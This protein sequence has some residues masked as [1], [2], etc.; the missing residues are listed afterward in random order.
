MIIFAPMNW[1]KCIYL[2][3]LFCAVLLVQ[4]KEG[5]ALQTAQEQF[6]AAAGETDFLFPD[7]GKDKSHQFNDEALAPVSGNALTGR[8]EQSSNYGRIL[9]QK[10]LFN[11]YAVF[12]DALSAS[13]VIR[14]GNF[15][16]R[17]FLLHPSGLHSSIHHLIRLRK[18]RN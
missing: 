14:P 9:S 13:T 5:S 17:A 7:D 11:R 16:D 15:T 1:K 6:C 3:L 4:Q 10:K 2:C 12:G 8:H 18:L